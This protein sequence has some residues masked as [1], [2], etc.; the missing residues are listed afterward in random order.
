M[1]NE[2]RILDYLQTLQTPWLNVLFMIITTLGNGGII[3]IIS[4]LIIYF[5]RDKRSGSAMII[6]LLMCLLIVNLLVK[7]IV[8]RARP[9]TVNT[10]IDLLIS[11]PTD[12]SFPSGHTCASFACVFALFFNHD[13][14]WKPAALLATLIAISRLYLYV[15]YPTDVLAGFIFGLIFGYI[16]NKI[17]NYC[18]LKQNKFAQKVL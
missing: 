9:F 8:A 7:P 17:L 1:L 16:A 4:A 18:Q 13:K 3:W 5:K 15:H 2:I 11:A 12:Y 6:A 10:S 14:L